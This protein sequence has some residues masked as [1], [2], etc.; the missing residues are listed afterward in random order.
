MLFGVRGDR[1]IVAGR[2]HQLYHYYALLQIFD[3]FSPPPPPFPSCLP[4][5]LSKPAFSVCSALTVRQFTPQ[6]PKGQ[7][8]TATERGCVSFV[9]GS[10]CW[11]VGLPRTLRPLPTS[12]CW[13]DTRTLTEQS[14][15]LTALP[16]SS[17]EATTTPTDR[18]TSPTLQHIQFQWR[19]SNAYWPV[20]I[21]NPST[22]TVPVTQQQRLLTGPHHQPLYIY[23]SS[24]A[25]TTPTGRSTS[26]TPQP[27]SSN[28]ATAVPTDRSTSPSL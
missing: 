18:S 24:D 9:S 3:T 20:H 26:P 5:M 17:S 4:L 12:T 7:W 10:S 25:T 15:L 27:D 8:L 1:G 19:N 6:P 23:S 21:A 11:R 14:T 22:C 13:L 28:D 2:R 16:G